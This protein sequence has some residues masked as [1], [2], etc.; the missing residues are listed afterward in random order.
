MSNQLFFFTEN[1]TV[2]SKHI[3]KRLPLRNTL[4]YMNRF[5][6]SETDQHEISGFFI[7]DN[8]TNIKKVK[9][10]EMAKWREEIE[11]K[12]KE[13]SEQ[14]ALKLPK[15]YGVVNFFLSGNALFKNLSGKSSWTLLIFD[16]IPY[17]ASGLTLTNKQKFYHK[18]KR[19][20]QN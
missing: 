16:S 11:K 20:T 5:S 6:I 9:S 4:N 7:L 14:L 18:L 2:N 1:P 12:R 17:H 15:C 10:S 19:R 13:I 8:P 3:S